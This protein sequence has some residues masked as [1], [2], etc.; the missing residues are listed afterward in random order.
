MSTTPPKIPSAIYRMVWQAIRARQNIAFEYQ[1]R[2]R[3]GSPIIL[4]YSDTGRE[5]LKLYQTAGK[6]SQGGLPDWRDFYLDQIRMLTVKAGEWREG[7]SQKHPQAFVKFVD[8]DINIPGTLTRDEPLA[9][10]SK[11]LRPPR[12]K[13]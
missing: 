4:G 10:G 7:T 5:A 11:E 12:G 9:F 2:P 1:G 3:E 6:S 13:K 8:V